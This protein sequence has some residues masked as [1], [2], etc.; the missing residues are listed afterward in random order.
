MWTRAFRFFGRF[1]YN[2]QKP[3]FCLSFTHL[4]HTKRNLLS[5]KAVLD[6][7]SSSFGLY[8]PLIRKIH[9]FYNPFANLSLFHT[10]SF[11]HPSY[12]A[13]PLIYKR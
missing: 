4:V 12:Y 7:A 3:P 11:L 13:V 10:F 1:F 9:S 8:D 6:H 5:G 2:G